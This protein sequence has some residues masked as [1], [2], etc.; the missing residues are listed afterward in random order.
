MTKQEAA[1]A[2][3]REAQEFRA[4]GDGSESDFKLAEWLRLCEALDAFEQAPDSAPAEAVG[5]RTEAQKRA[6]SPQ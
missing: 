3:V 2:V 6:E 5:E 4:A 1:L